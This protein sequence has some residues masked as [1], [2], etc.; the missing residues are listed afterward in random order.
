MG[1]LRFE[2]I[3][4]DFNLNDSQCRQVKAELKGEKHIDRSAI[5]AFLDSL[6]YP[7]YFI[8]FES[9]Q[10]AVPLF[11]R[12][13]PYQQVVFQYSMHIRDSI[14]S[15]VIHK[16]FLADAD[17]NDP[18]IPFIKQ[19]I[20]DIGE[21][22][23]IIV[24]N[25][26]FE[27]SRLNELAASFPEYEADIV[28]INSRMKDLMLIFQQ[29]Q[30]YIPEMK[31]SYSIKQILPAMVP[32]FSYDNMPIG[33]GG[34]ASM[35]FTSLFSEPDDEKNRMIRENLLEYCKLDTL[36]MVEIVIALQKLVVIK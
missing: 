32:G 12:S 29:R 28:R 15:E 8:D 16:A 30:Y 14:S 22:G 5:K 20:T 9:F 23:D 24:F 4:D 34:S 2:D 1:I 36:A 26:S 10:P 33:D 17:G 6:T 35:A 18:R 19:L 21:E 7:I 13:R 25:R 11:D 31:G 27:S 3:P